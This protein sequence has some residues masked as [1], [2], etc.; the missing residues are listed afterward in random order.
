YF[1]LKKTR[2]EQRGSQ[3]KCGRWFYPPPRSWNIYS[4]KCLYYLCSAVVKHEESEAKRLIFFIKENQGG[5]AWK[6][7]EDVMCPARVE[8]GFPRMHCEKG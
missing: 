1:S 8:H 6:S 7:T 5:A 3:Q 4:L 2:E